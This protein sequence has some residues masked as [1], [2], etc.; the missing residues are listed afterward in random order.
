MKKS[1]TD[2]FLPGAVSAELEQLCAAV[3]QALVRTGAGLEERYYVR[4][5][6]EATRCAKRSQARGEESQ[7]LEKEVRGEL[8]SLHRSSR[9]LLQAYQLML[10]TEDEL[11]AR[12]RDMRSSRDKKWYVP[13]PP[14]NAA[15]DLAES[16]CR[17]FAQGLNL[18]KLLLICF[19]GSF[20]GV[21]ME[22]IWCV[23][24]YGFIESR[25][26]LVYGPFNLLYGAGAVL[27]TLALF[28][29]RNRGPVWSF[30]GGFLVGSA[31]EYVCSWA[32]EALLGSRSWDYSAMPLN[33]NGRICLMYSTFWGSLGVLWIKD[34]SPRMAKWI[35]KIPNRLG[36]PLTWA[37]T[38]FLIFNSLVSAVAV[39]RWAERV[40]GEPASGA[41]EEFVD[42]RF[43]DERLERVF[44]NMKFGEPTAQTD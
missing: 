39:A 20:A 43:P 10:T 7:A 29:F 5:A 1:K 13:N 21:V 18:Y 28:R 25:A 31:L 14:A 3:P 9:H 22:M 42:R 19:V 4:L 40:N 30:L 33:V 27:L 6:E 38:A 26:G 37:V 24:R 17:H 34:L 12:L 23:L 35:L 41:F 16:K 44:A 2:E 15:I 36:R 11:N 8:S 32:Q